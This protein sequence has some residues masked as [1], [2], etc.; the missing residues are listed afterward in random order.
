[1]KPVSQLGAI[2]QLMAHSLA[3]M[4]LQS[5]HAATHSQFR[6]RKNEGNNAAEQKCGTQFAAVQMSDAGRRKE[7]ARQ[8]AGWGLALELLEYPITKYTVSTLRELRQEGT[9]DNRKTHCRKGRY[10]LDSEEIRAHLAL[11]QPSIPTLNTPAP[12]R[13]PYP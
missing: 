5:F 12:F 8:M 1:M 2:S 10:K 6:Q 13:I 11:S 3:Y 7:G 4:F 9:R